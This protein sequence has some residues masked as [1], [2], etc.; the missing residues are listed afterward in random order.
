[1]GVLMIR[2]RTALAPAILAALCL[3][4]PVQEALQ[5]SAI[6]P[7]FHLDGAFRTFG[8]LQRMRSGQFPGEDFFRIWESAPSCSYF[9]PSGFWEALSQIQFSHRR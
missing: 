7:V 5:V 1:M 3:Y 4:I 8:R 9:Q 2:L 6:V